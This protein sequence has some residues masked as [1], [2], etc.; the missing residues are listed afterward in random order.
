MYHK[1]TG[2]PDHTI[3]KTVT[4]EDL[5]EALKIQIDAEKEYYNI[6]LK[7][8]LAVKRTKR[9]ELKSRL[10]ELT[11]TIQLANKIL[12]KVLP[13]Y[14]SNTVLLNTLSDTA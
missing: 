3:A 11:N 13:G 1:Q 7:L 14:Q 2:S 5:T 4:E 10:A 9:Q 6:L 8:D 12:N